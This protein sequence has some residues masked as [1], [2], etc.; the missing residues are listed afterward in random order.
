MKKFVEVVLHR[1]FGNELSPF[2]YSVPPELAEKVKV[3]QLIKAPFGKKTLIGVISQIIEAAPAFAAKDIEEIINQDPV[4]QPWQIKLLHWISEQYFC[5]IHSALKTFLPSAILKP[6]KRK[7]KEKEEAQ[8]T[9]IPAKKL[10]ANQEEVIK[11]ILESQQQKFLLHGITGAGKTEIYL[12]IA[13]SLAEDEQLILLVPEISLTPQLIDYFSAGT[14]QAIA[15]IHSRLSESEKR[16]IWQK[17]QRGENKIVIGSRSALFAPFPNLKHIIIDEEHEWSYKQ[18][19]TPRY[20]TRTVAEKICSILPGCKFLLASATPSIESYYKAQSGEYHLFTI[21]ERAINKSELPLVHVVDLRE[22]L[23]K[24]NY[25]IFSDTLQD[26]ITEKLAKQEQ[27]ILF[28]NRRGAASSVSC[29]DCGEIVKCRHCDVAMTYH[30]SNN[31]PR[32]ICHYCGSIDSPPTKCPNCSSLHIKL[33]GIGTQKIE[34]ETK[35]L[36]PNARVFRADRDTT[37]HKDSFTELYQKLKNREIDILIGT[38]MIGKG[39]HLPKV[40]LVGVILADIGLHVPDFRSSEKTFQTIT[41]VAGRSGRKDP[42]EVVLQ[43]YL[44][45]HPAIACAKQH[46]YLSFYNSEIEARRI[47]KYPPFNEIIRLL[48]T[49]SDKNKCIQ[50]HNRVKALLEQTIKEQGLE[51]IE[52]MAH[53]ALI[54]RIHN[55]YRYIISLKGAD[56]AKLISPLMPQL[57]Q[58]KIDRDPYWN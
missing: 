58:W 56:P 37:S 41:Q 28:L 53:P 7:R 52:I 12:Q 55:K 31:S 24:G 18:D 5:S 4:L 13:K 10:T 42:G 44:P 26:K 46:D 35:K 3:G 14:G 23:Q 36:F 8:I 40:N 9:K 1:S 47:L 43:T 16:N 17:I 50:E 27:I 19:Q 51:E 29:R 20:H 25:S 57:N 34:Q 33:V 22:E 38:Q 2:T 32:L 6:V 15:A 21:S 45:D 11:T 49:H 30:N 39:L 48:I 54:E